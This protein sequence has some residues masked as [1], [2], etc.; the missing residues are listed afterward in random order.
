LIV[1][2]TVP[3]VLMALLWVAQE[4]VGVL[5]LLE[6]LRRVWHRIPVRMDLHRSLL[7]RFAQLLLRHLG[8]NPD[9]VVQSAV[10]NHERE[11]KTSFCARPLSDIWEN[12][13][14]GC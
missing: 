8:L 2:D 5:Q 12:R 4:L 3:I 7:V 11:A 10:D 9:D 13:S 1:R 14:S 6:L